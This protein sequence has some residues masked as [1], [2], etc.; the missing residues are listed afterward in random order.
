M[1]CLLLIKTDY[2][3]FLSSTNFGEEL[4]AEN[5][6]LIMG[7]TYLKTQDFDSRNFLV[8]EIFTHPEF[9]NSMKLNDIAL[10]YLRS[11]IQWE[12]TIVKALPLNTKPLASGTKCIVLG[13]GKTV[14]V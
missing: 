4:F 14:T 13:W 11:S 3:P 6:L 9:D 7:S 5:L 8:Q 10:L 12:L 2:V 1:I